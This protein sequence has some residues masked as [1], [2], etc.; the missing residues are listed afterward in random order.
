M[1]IDRKKTY[2]DRQSE[3]SRAKKQPQQKNVARDTTSQ[4]PGKTVKDATKKG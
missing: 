3:A 2:S 4:A 1:P